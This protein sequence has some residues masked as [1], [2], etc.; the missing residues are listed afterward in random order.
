MALE[1]AVRRRRSPCRI[2]LPFSLTRKVSGTRTPPLGTFLLAGY[3]MVDSG[4]KR[5]RTVNRGHRRRD[6][7]GRGSRNVR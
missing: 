1:R 3:G 5:I 6:G 2:R 7:R 4:R